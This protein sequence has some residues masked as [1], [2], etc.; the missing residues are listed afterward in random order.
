MEMYFETNKKLFD[1]IERFCRKRLISPSTEDESFDEKTGSFILVWEGSKFVINHKLDVKE[2]IKEVASK[3]I[4]KEIGEK[5]FI[6]FY[7]TPSAKLLHGWLK[8]FYCSQK[9]VES[10]V[11][12]CENLNKGL[13]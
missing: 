1:F 5:E 4:E 3:G 10:M 13:F 11:I 2:E 8:E 7:Q 12:L 9:N 6:Y